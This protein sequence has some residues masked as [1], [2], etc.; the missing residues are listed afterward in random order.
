MAQQPETICEAPERN[1][2][3]PRRD[4]HWRDRGDIDAEQIDLRVIHARTWA[5]K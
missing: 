1:Q 4:N 3:Q 2:H 5:S